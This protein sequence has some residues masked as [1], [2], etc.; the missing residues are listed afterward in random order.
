MCEGNPKNA[1]AYKKSIDDTKANI[2]VLKN[3]IHDALM[4]NRNLCYIMLELNKS[5]D[6]YVCTDEV[7]L[8]QQA[9]VKLLLDPKH[10]QHK[11]NLDIHTDVVKQSSS[12]WYKLH[13]EARVTGST[14]YKALGLDSLKAEKEHYDKFI[15]AKGKKEFPC[16]VRQ[17]MQ[18]GSENEVMYK[19][20]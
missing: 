20:I 9:N 16:D 14:L 7:N 18:H 4:L 6:L 17:R 19:Y 1:K 3:W 5:N 2:Y 8:S 15:L 11:V 10:F 12:K 13:K